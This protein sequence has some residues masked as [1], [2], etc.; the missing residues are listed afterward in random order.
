MA[1]GQSV[2]INIVFIL[3]YSRYKSAA[4]EASQDGYTLLK[5]ISYNLLTLL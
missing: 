5:V 4:Y 2:D 1:A 3:I